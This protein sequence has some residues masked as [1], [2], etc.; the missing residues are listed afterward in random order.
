MHVTIGMRATY[1]MISC[2][3]SISKAFFYLRGLPV[4]GYG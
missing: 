1:E 4:C 3:A 2:L